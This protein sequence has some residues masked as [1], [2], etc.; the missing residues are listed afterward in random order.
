MCH[1][2]AGAPSPDQGLTVH[3]QGDGASGYC[4]MHLQGDGASGYCAIGRRHTLGRVAHA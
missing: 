1:A 4:A 3:L 2:T